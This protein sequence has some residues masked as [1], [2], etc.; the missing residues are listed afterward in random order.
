LYEETIRIPTKKRLL[1][2]GIIF[3]GIIGIYTL[4]SNLFTDQSGS[5]IDFKKTENIYID[6]VTTILSF[7]P[8]NIALFCV[9]IVSLIFSFLAVWG[10]TKSRNGN[11]YAVIISPQGIIVNN[12]YV[13]TGLINWK[14]IKDVF[15]FKVER[16]HFIGINLVDQENHDF[17][18]NQNKWIKML[19]YQYPPI[20]IPSTA[21]KG[22]INGI[23]DLI[24]NYFQR[25]GQ[26][27]SVTKVTLEKK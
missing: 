19:N 16:I 14:D 10:V 8:P 1:Y 9:G 22:N 5:N 17:R 20:S 21:V 4:Y 23:H 13:H 3:F 18:K 15:M 7:L 12:T 2:L 6:A 24:Q 25:Y 26:D 27:N 11:G